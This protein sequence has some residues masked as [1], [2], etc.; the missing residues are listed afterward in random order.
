MEE[1]MRRPELPPVHPGEILAEEFLAPLSISQNRLARDLA[2]PAQRVSQI[3]RGE[4]AVTLDTALRLAAYFKTSPE[5][6][7][8]LQQQY[9]LR[10]ARAQHLP[11]R[12]EREVRPMDVAQA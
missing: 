4:R 1:R 2:V 12:I 5:F 3:V 11:E 8:N 9:D 7:L 10:T 6:W